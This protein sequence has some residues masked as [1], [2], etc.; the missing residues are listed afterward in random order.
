MRI[1]FVSLPSTSWHLHFQS[2]IV[3]T[4]IQGG[5]DTY[6]YPPC[7]YPSTRQ[8]RSINRSR[9]HVSG[10]KREICLPCVFKQAIKNKIRPDIKNKKCQPKLM[11]CAVVV[12][13]LDNGRNRTVQFRY[14]N[15]Q[16]GTPAPYCMRTIKLWGLQ[17]SI[18]FNEYH[19]LFNSSKQIHISRHVRAFVR[20]HTGS[21]A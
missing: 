11:Q 1:Y 16:A 19:H 14:S 17:C 3:G 9:F 10:E 20:L 13:W 15:R 6:Y 4:C 21:V 8:A 7:L 12:S 18:S 2:P 5:Y